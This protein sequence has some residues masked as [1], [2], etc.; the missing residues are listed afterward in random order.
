MKSHSVHHY[1]KCLRNKTFKES[2][3]IR[4]QKLNTAAQYHFIAAMENGKTPYYVRDCRR[5]FLNNGFPYLIFIGDRE[6]D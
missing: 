4:S 3:G 5:Y 2:Q 1:G 6:V